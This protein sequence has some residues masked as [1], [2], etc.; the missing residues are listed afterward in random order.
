MV[1]DVDANELI[2]KCNNISNDFNQLSDIPRLL[3]LKNNKGNGHV[4]VFLY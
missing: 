4:G 1:E 3:H 2:L